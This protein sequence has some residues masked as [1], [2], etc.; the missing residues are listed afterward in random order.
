M[1]TRPGWRLLGIAGVLA[2]ALTAPARIA[3]REQADTVPDVAVKAALLY[4]FAKFVQWPALQTGAP[5]LVCVVGSR[6]IADAVSITVLGQSIDGHLLNLW[7]SDDSAKWPG[8]NLLFVASS[9][10]GHAAGGLKNLRTEPVL[11][12]SDRSGELYVEGGRMR[13]AINVEAAERSGLHLSSRLLGLARIVRS[14]HDE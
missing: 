13:F 4:S 14:E 8:C 10:I 9:E 3:A 1:F 12:V 7:P 5:I 6:A 11:T 2:T